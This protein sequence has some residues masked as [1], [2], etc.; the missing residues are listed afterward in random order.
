M[1]TRILVMGTALAALAGCE[2]PTYDPISEDMFVS[3]PVTTAPLNNTA[4]PSP[5][6]SAGVE[7]V[8]EDPYVQTVEGG[9]DGLTERLPDTCRLEN[10]QQYRGRSGADVAAA[11]LSAPYRVVAL[12]DIV[13]QEYNPMR[14]NFYTDGSGQITQISC[15]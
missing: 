2:S 1:K 11:G 10:Y 3:N 6:Y 4:P 7:A 5:T 9:A 8:E 15:G 14:V 13:T 12:T